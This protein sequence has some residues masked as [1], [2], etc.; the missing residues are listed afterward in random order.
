MLLWMVEFAYNNAEHSSLGCSPFFCHTGHHP[1][2][3]P[4]E[5]PVQ[6]KHPTI[7]EHHKHLRMVLQSAIAQLASA[8]TKD[9][10]YADR[11]RFPET[12]YKLGNKVWLNTKHLRIKGNTSLQPKFVGLYPII[13]IV[14]PVAMKLQ[15]PAAWH[16]HP[17]FHVSLLRLCLPHSRLLQKALPVTVEGDE[18]YKVKAIL[19][20]KIFRGTV[21]YLIDWKGYGPEERSWE[22]MSH[23]HC[24][25]LLR[26]FHLRYPTKHGGL[27]RRRPWRGGTV[28][29]RLTGR[30]Q[31]NL[32]AAVCG[33]RIPVG[34]T[35]STRRL[36]PE[37]D[38]G[39]AGYISPTPLVSGACQS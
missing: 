10:K 37:N 36:R 26:R 30:H 9:K 25:D 16:I 23:L 29:T 19:D 18:E 31:R 3:L 5:W 12:H 34:E 17:V 20:S 22:P 13:K 14:N 24:D 27:S 6:T 38:D 33:T 32:H 15:L 8:Q 4:F 28:T 7:Q 39:L 35:T 21:R 2:M 11:K 1:N